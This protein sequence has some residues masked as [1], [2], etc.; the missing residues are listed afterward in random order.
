MLILDNTKKKMTSHG[1]GIEEEQ[2]SRTEKGIQKDCHGGIE[3]VI[4]TSPTIVCLTQKVPLYIG[5][6][7]SGSLLAS[8]TLR[9][10]FNVTPEAFF[11]TTP[12]DSVARALVAEIIISFLLMF[13]ISG[14][15]TDS[16]AI[17]ELAGIAV[18]MTIILNVFVAG[19]ISGA[20]MNPARSLG[21][22]IVMGVYKGIWIYIVGP[23]V[24]I[25][26]G[27][28]VYNFIRFTD[29]P[30][31]ELT[32][33][34]SFLRSA[35]QSSSATLHES[36]TPTEEPQI[37]EVDDRTQNMK[38]KTSHDIVNH[39]ETRLLS[40]EVSLQTYSSPSTQA[41]S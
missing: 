14:V 26:A 28:F 5:A 36:Q 6:Q 40:H 35:S 10:M 17:G 24:G 15:A 21:P 20:S 12:A 23:I 9:L 30:L 34:A 33:S 41:S 29:K 1:E 4:C 16:R 39:W 3:T 31:Q 37:T 19:P 25:M 11:G 38:T 13:V 22:A 7:L 2:I 18:G 32:K 8:L 27:G